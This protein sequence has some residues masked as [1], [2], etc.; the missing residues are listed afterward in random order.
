MTNIEPPEAARP[1]YRDPDMFIAVAALIVSFTAVAVGIYEAALQRKHDRAEVWPH[2]EIATYAKPSG[3]VVYLDNTGIGPGIVKEIVVTVDGKPVQNWSAVFEAL[4]GRDPGQFST[5]TVL[6]H[7]MRPGDRIALADVP[8]A[9]LPDNLWDAIK[10]VEV[11]IC[12]AS[13]FDE[14]WTVHLPQLGQEE[15]WTSVKRC[16][17][18]PKNVYF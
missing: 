17:P 13:V 8:K 6:N 16:P 14:Y 10:R 4:T 7:G 2:L 9:A 5:S 1:W 3:A 11:T 12:Y 15:V 18:Q